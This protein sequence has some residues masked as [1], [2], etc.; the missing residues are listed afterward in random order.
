LE[1][2]VSADWEGVLVEGGERLKS[3]SADSRRQKRKW[4]AIED[5]MDQHLVAGKEDPN[6]W[7]E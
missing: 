4:K 2:W 6:R 3:V 5:G 7:I 1:R